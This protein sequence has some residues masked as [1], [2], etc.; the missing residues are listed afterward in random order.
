MKKL[1]RCVA[2]FI[3]G[4]LIFQVLT[5]VFV[6]KWNSKIDPATP[7]FKEFYRQEKNSI[8]VLAV[9]A[10][11]VGRGY[12]P[13]KVW[14]EYGITSFN[15]GTSNQTFSLAYYLIDE[16]IK[17]QKPKVIVLD[18]DALFVEKDAPEGE[19][20]KLFDNLKLDNVKIQAIND[21]KVRAGDKLP[22]IFPLLRFHSR[23][24]E[25]EEK[26]FK[27]KSLN[28]KYKELSFMGMA[29]SEEIKPYVDAKQYMEDKGET[30]KVSDENLY[31]TEKIIDLCKKNDIQLLWDELPSATSWSY[32]RYEKTLELAKKY[33]IEFIDYNLADMM[34]NLNFN[35]MT[36]TA[37]GG[38]HLNVQGAE[39]ISNHIGKILSEKYNCKDY[40]KDIE[41]AKVWNEVVQR[42]D[43]NR[44]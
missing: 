25:L 44:E 16:A 40:R 41:K 17:Y 4:F 36:D 20:R 1:I 24:S 32:A 27:T 23:Y 3:I 8:D 42:Y 13:V 34:Y 10:S 7:R 18:M 28:E 30:E 29:M 35:W 37:D 2:F 22:Y 6:P 26:D 12:S 15:L 5:Y 33:N 14:K 21:E 19:Y 31:Y 9:G 11:D 39:K 38:N 43:N